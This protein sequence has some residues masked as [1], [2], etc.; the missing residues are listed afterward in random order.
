MLIERDNGCYRS[1]VSESMAA[2][3]GVSRW[4]SSFYSSLASPP[5]LLTQES[6]FPARLIRDFHMLS[7]EF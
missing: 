1:G 6:G 4:S 5:Y 2:D 3:C 7:F